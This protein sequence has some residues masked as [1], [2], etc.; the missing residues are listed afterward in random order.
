M[1]RRLCPDRERATIAGG[2]AMVVLAI[3][4]AT[5]SNRCDCRLRSDRLGLMRG[6]PQLRNTKRSSW[7]CRG[8]GRRRPALLEP[9]LGRLAI[10]SI[11]TRSVE[12]IKQA[13][14]RR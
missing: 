5:R 9:D 4:S 12:A 1:A 13:T 11:V 3:P 10:D 8:P 7:I 6:A 14:A 2:A